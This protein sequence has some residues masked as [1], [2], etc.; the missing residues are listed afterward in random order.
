MEK[1]LKSGMV[2]SVVFHTPD[3]EGTEYFYIYTL[4]SGLDCKNATELVLYC[5]NF[6]KALIRNYGNTDFHSPEPV[7]PYSNR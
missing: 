4:V 3:Y 7:F 2:R 1:G 5:N 6:P